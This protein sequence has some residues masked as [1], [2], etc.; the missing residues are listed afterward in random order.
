MMN[1]S[2]LQ[3]RR[4]LKFDRRYHGVNY[5]SEDRMKAINSKNQAIREYCDERYMAIAEL[6]IREIQKRNLDF[7]DE[8]ILNILNI[9]LKTKH[10]A[11]LERQMDYFGGIQGMINAVKRRYNKSKQE[12]QTNNEKNQGRNDER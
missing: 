9:L 6:T 1:Y 12:Q 10:F 11:R 4:I 3:G 2:S 5:K 7:K 8:N